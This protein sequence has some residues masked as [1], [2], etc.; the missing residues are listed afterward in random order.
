VLAAAPAAASSCCGTVHSAIE[1]SSALGAA[2]QLSAGVTVHV[3]GQEGT[4][5]LPAN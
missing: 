1:C 4:R 3:V 2:R 5:F